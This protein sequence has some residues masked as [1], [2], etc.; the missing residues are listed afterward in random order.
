MV[1]PDKSPYESPM[2][3]ISVRMIEL[4]QATME[5]GQ[6]T[7]AAIHT[8]AALAL[9]NLRHLVVIN[10]KG[11]EI[12]NT[13]CA[14]EYFYKFESNR[15]LLTRLLSMVVMV[16]G[17]LDIEARN[18][19]FNGKFIKDEFINH[20]ENW[21]KRVRRRSILNQIE[22]YIVDRKYILSSVSFMDASR[23]AQRCIIEIRNF[24]VKDMRDFTLNGVLQTNYQSEM[25]SIMRFLFFLTK[26]SSTEFELFFQLISNLVITCFT[27]LLAISRATV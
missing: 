25:K 27:A 18:M 2:L 11:F 1:C 5:L 16:L 3:D 10:V 7:E 19:Q 20:L 14:R 6:A 12:L 8:E 26:P 22:S 24:I 15:I 17:Y 23:H 21:H 4:G 9:V 13:V